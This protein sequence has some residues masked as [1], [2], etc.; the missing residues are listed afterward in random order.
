MPLPAALEALRAADLGFPEGTLERVLERLRS[1]ETLADSMRPESAFPPTY[2]WL[3]GASEARGD[4]PS[5]LQA[6]ALRHERDYST[7]LKLFESLVAPIAM[8]AIGL[9]VGISVLSIFL[10]IFEMQRALQS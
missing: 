1:G 9:V 7:R 6:L 5:A 2:V 10:P 4:L 8:C 3:V